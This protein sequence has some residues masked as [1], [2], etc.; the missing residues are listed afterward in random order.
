[1]QTTVR[2]KEWSKAWAEYVRA[3]K[4][5]QGVEEA[6]AKAKAVWTQDGSKWFGK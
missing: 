1:M 6:R 3:L 2:A 5:G 4:T